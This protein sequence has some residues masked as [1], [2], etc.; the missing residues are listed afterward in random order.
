M[1]SNENEE[2]EVGLGTGD[3]GSDD[4]NDCA[5]KARSSRAWVWEGC[6]C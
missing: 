6:C 5:A 3:S 1:S 2:E 4:R